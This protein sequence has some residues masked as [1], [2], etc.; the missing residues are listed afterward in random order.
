MRSNVTGVSLTA[1]LLITACLLTSVEAIA[2]TEQATSV[3][4]PEAKNGG[5]APKPFVAK[6]FRVPTRVETEQFTLVPLGPALAK[7]D[8]AAYMSSIA[9]LQKTF[10]HSTGWPREGISDADAMKDMETEAARFQNR[11]SFAYAVLTPDGKR[12]RGCIYVSPSTVDGYDAVV[13][14]WVTQ[15][16]YNA[17]F[18]SKLYAWAID[19][20][21][22]DWP[23]ENVSY[24]GRSMEWSTWIELVAASKVEKTRPL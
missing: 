5:G 1:M 22:R 16:E 8:Y 23:F 19:W 6:S 3:M 21:Q 18:D 14:L 12:E 13:R 17:G 20:M 24:P 15:D 7:V 4:A 11:Q 9:H 10:S 2:A